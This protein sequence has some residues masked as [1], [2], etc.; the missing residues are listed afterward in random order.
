[1]ARPAP[2]GRSRELS[3][4]GT[5][6]HPDGGRGDTVPTCLDA[7]G[8][9]A[10]T[11]PTPSGSCRRCRAGAAGAAYGKALRISPN[12]PG[13]SRPDMGRVGERQ[14]RPVRDPV[15]RVAGR[16]PRHPRRPELEPA[17][18]HHARAGL[19]RPEGHPLR[20]GARSRDRAPARRDREDHEH[21]DLRLRPAPLRRLHARHGER[22]RDGPRADGRG[23]RGRGR[24]QGQA[25]G[26][27]PH[28]H[29]VHDHLRP[30][31]PVPPRQLLG[32]RD[33]QPQQ[34]P[35]RQGLRAHHGRPVRLHPPD[36]RLPGRAGP[37]PARA[38]RQLDPRQGAREH[39][40][41]EGAVP[42][43]HPADRLAGGRAG[44]HPADRHGRDLGLRAGRP[45]D[46]PQRRAPGRQ[47]GGRD[48]RRARAPRAW[49]GP[50]GRP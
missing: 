28:R 35:G 44:R 40:R 21:G 42:L 16:R 17:G 46:H 45:D 34:G 50:A 9:S 39:P 15:G 49:R 18:K 8:H 10:T 23:G 38:V 13:R 3:R 19:A 27:R 41:R 30:V 1:M 11:G 37:V 48:R 29:P 36:R 5:R 32:V 2:G 7:D 25:Q 26:R 4:G 31:R 12:G 24:G 20:H 47:A 43:R 14:R 33:D 6:R 22:R